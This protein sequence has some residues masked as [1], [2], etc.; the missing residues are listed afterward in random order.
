ML[1]SRLLRLAWGE[2]GDSPFT[3]FSSIF[4][5]AFVAASAFILFGVSTGL[6]DI[7]RQRLLG[8]L[9]NYIRVEA[10]TFSLG[11]ISTENW[12]SEDTLLQL[13]S[14]KG[15]NNVFRIARLKRPASLT[16]NYAGQHF[17]SDI[18]I[19]AID[20]EFIE[21]FTQSSSSE[22]LSS[23]SK[24]SQAPNELPYYETDCLLSSSVVDAL[25][26][27]VSIH[28]DLPNLTPQALIGRHFNLNIGS[29]TFS[30]D[31]QKKVR[32]RCR[33][34]GISPLVG[35]SGPNIPYDLAQK[36][37]SEPLKCYAA[38]LY[39]KNNEDISY[40]LQNL[41]SM[42][43]K[44]PG[45]DLAKQVSQAFVWIHLGITI[46]CLL[47]S[48]CAG[49]TIL[50]NLNLEIKIHSRKL[51]LYRALGAAPVDIF[52]LYIIRILTSSLIGAGLG[53]SLGCIGGNII[54]KLTAS[55]SIFSSAEIFKFYSLNC[56]LVLLATVGCTLL[57]C[58]FPLYRGCRLSFSEADEN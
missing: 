44:A 10:K 18:F 31:S 19:D 20:K 45:I 15:V 12:L 3:K 58:L 11:P 35:V 24:L 37:S 50:S 39:I 51:A 40:I 17:V 1:F 7:A 47:L 52:S 55:Y 43:L 56:Y 14:I 26:S 6:E 2:L 25:L 16:A 8:D 54:N 49:F 53:I 9:P 33:I 27:G 57:F 38:L 22:N 29:S 36:L 23:Y 13:E 32:L 42:H 5:L 34:V 41:E 21:S 46:F 4:S 48:C 30:S 28:T